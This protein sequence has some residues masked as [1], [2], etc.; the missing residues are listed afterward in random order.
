[1]AL[2]L[3][4]LFTFVGA[5]GPNANPGTIGFLLLTLALA[6]RRGERTAAWILGGLG[7]IIGI[8]QLLHDQPIGSTLALILA[9]TSLWA[10]FGSVT[11]S[12]PKK[13][14][15]DGFAHSPSSRS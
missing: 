4:A 8:D 6:L 12:I 3:G 15:S 2:I 9:V 7:A 5:F 10:G 14:V 13:A 11:R 1:V